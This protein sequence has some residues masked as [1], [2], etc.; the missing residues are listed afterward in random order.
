ME[1]NRYIGPTAKFKEFFV[2]L[3][4]KSLAIGVN[5]LPCQQYAELSD[6]A[7]SCAPCAHELRSIRDKRNEKWSLA[8]AQHRAPFSHH[9]LCCTSSQM[10]RL[11]P[12][13]AANRT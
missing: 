2:F 12:G 11:R 5:F 7:E 8:A 10:I 1:H 4:Q 3:P 6:T 9:F 13:K